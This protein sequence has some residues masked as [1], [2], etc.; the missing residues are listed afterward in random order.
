MKLL[1][2]ISALLVFGVAMGDAVQNFEKVNL[3][4]TQ[5]PQPNATGQELP[6]EPG[7][8]IPYVRQKSYADL[9][10]EK[11]AKHLMDGVKHYGRAIVSVAKAINEGAI[12]PLTTSLWPKIRRLPKKIGKKLSRWAKVMSGKIFDE[13]KSMG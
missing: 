3:N 11:A 2:L 6:G 1:T 12:K 8:E 9:Q 4:D 10:E 5:V 13:L 7:G